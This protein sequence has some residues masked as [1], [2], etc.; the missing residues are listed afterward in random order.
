[1]TRLS[2]LAAAA[3]VACIPLG[4]A[5]AATAATPPDWLHVVR[6][7]RYDGVSDDLVTG[8]VGIAGLGG[9]APPFADPAAPTFAE[10]RRAILRRPPSVANG[11]GRL[12]GANVDPATGRVSGD[13]RIA[14]DEVLAYADDGSGAVMAGLLL[15]VPVTFDPA[16][17][18]IVAVATPGSQNVWADM[19]RGGYWGLTHGC[20]VVWAD[21]G[22]GAG[23]YD[24]DSRRGVAIDGQLTDRAARLLPEDSAALRAFAASHPHRLGYKWAHGGWTQEADWGQSVLRAVQF[25]LHELGSRDWPG[26]ASVT[27][28]NTKVIASGFSN[29]GGAVLKAAEQDET[30]LIDGVV[31]MSPQIMTPAS[32]R[33]VIEQGE[34]RRVG[35]NRTIFDTLSF[36]NLYRSCA[37]LALP[38]TPG[39]SGLKFAANRC[40][41][42]A[43]A[44]LLEAA[45][46]PAQAR[47]SLDRLHAFGMQPEA[48]SQIAGGALAEQSTLGQAS[49][50]GRFRIEENLCGLSFAAVDQD[51]RPR[52]ATPAESAHWFVSQLGGTPDGRVVTVINEAARGGARQSAASVSRSTGRQDYNFDAALCLRE[53]A[54]GSSA[55]ALR[56]QAGL[57]SVLATGD[58]RSR[59]TLIVHGRADP[60]EPPDF[61][62]RAYLGLHSLVAARPDTLRYIEV[63]RATHGEPGPTAA[64]LV[65][66]SPYQLQA[67]EAMWAHLMQGK[68]LPPSQLVRT[69]A[70]SGTAGGK[71]QVEA[72]DLPPIAASPRRADRIV[73]R[74]G[75]VTVPD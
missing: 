9:A 15:Q 19:Q 13:G 5:L 50:Y 30:G 42:L 57:R 34:R 68:P 29:G 74:D 38:D 73:A 3:L 7:D 49:Q 75:R 72:A 23:V 18:C 31:A 6:R 14:G 63:T 52:V 35:G 12:F 44:G 28:A 25:A 59:P 66:L 58:L 69:A 47:E 48:D 22:L 27:R 10:M 45:E 16:R 20:A 33:V 24:L 41:S 2:T 43:D 56:V 55:N 8:G 60:V 21:K 46:L 36:G 65:P 51:G 17:A 64:G 67:L 40:A 39:A 53:L 54:T 37:A 4:D 1:M 32:E 70:P 71:P 62:S 61:T 11:F 26:G